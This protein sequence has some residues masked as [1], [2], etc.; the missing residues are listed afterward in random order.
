MKTNQI[1]KVNFAGIDLSIG[2]KDKMGNL[3]ELV[4]IGNRYR[5]MK[6]LS[7]M[8]VRDLLRN[9]AI[10]EYVIMLEN[11]AAKNQRVTK[12]VDSTHL[13][14]LDIQK[15]KNKSGQLDI[16]KN[17]TV[18]KSK[19][20]KYGGTWAHLNIMIRVA[21][22][23]SPEFADQVINTFIEGKLIKYRD[24]GGITFKALTSAY[25]GWYIRKH[26]E[27]ATPEKYKEV[28]RYVKTTVGVHDW[29]KATEDQDEFRIRMHEM[30]YYIYNHDLT[31]KE[32]NLLM[33]TVISKFRPKVL[34]L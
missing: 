25:Q 8:N 17:L 28:A 1:L 2:H 3:N 10:A 14:L 30:M 23:M 13:E 12:V 5:E 9:K 29:N 22:E 34:P 7:A 26:K 24:V 31:K 15:L 33:D 6:R 4:A 21:I 19:R 20:G 32:A 18:L 27:E 16:P 11:K